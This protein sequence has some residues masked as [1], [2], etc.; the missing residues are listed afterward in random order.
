MVCYDLVVWCDISMPIIPT[1]EIYLVLGSD[2]F[3]DP[4]TKTA[5][6]T[7]DITRL[8][9]HTI[10]AIHHYPHVYPR[11]MGGR[12]GPQRQTSDNIICEQPARSISLKL[13]KE[14]NVLK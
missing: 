2:G 12:E 5:M 10:W 8:T 4:V 7:P 11:L 14:I 13:I 3:G 9:P 1:E 6:F